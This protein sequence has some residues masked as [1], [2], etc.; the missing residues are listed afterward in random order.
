M[1]SSGSQADRLIEANGKLATAA[2]KS[3][4]ISDKNLIATQRAWIGPVDANITQG[5]PYTIVKATVLYINTGKEPAKFQLTGV[6][7]LYT[8]EQWDNGQ[9]ATSLTKGKSDCFNTATI[10]GTRFAWPTTGF[11]NYFAHIPEGRVP[12]PGVVVWTDRLNNGDDLMTVQGCIIYEAFGEIHHTA[13]C[14]FYD[15]RLSDMSHLNICTVGNDV[16]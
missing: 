6:E 14:Y 4:D 1:N 5:T 9:A 10:T 8:R 16:N 13:F 11:S 15:R 3:A 2:Q 7:N 12:Q